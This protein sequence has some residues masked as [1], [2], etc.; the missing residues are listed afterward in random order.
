MSNQ[1]K[2]NAVVIWKDNRAVIMVSS[3][4]GSEPIQRVKKQDRK[5]KKEVSAD[6]SYLVH[7]YNTSIGGTDRQDQNVNKYTISIHTKKW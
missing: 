6:M 5:E 4:F 7:K 3:C 2:E 1:D